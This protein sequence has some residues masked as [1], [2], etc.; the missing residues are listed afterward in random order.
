VPADLADDDGAPGYLD[1]LNEQII[2]AVQRA[3]HVYPSNAIVRGS[4][5][6]RACLVGYRTEAEHLEALVDDVVRF[7]RQLDRQPRSR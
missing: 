7:G 4:F 1:E 2:Y 3:G 6:I 5:A